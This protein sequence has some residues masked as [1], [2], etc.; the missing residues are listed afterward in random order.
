MTT[1]SQTAL[2]LGTSSPTLTDL[3]TLAGGV[4]PTGTI[5]FTLHAPGGTSVVDTETVAVNGNGN[6]TTPTGYTPP[7]SG[8]VTGIY[9]WTASY[10][11]RWE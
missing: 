11:R 2:T 6:Y 1:P 8:T 5:T 7:K 4:N 3:A 10:S 9:Q